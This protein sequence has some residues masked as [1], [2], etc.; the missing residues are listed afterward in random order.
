M[1]CI[2]YVFALRFREVLTLCQ[3]DVFFSNTFMGQSYNPSAMLGC[4][5]TV[6][7][8]QHIW[9]NRLQQS[10]MVLAST[11]QLPQYKTLKQN[12]FSAAAADIV[13]RQLINMIADAK[14]FADPPYEVFNAAN[15]G[16]EP[17]MRVGYKR[18]DGMTTQIH[19]GRVDYFML[20]SFCCITIYR[21]SQATKLL[22]PGC[23][24]LRRKL[25]PVRLLRSNSNFK[26]RAVSFHTQAFRKIILT[27]S[28]VSLALCHASL[29][30]SA[31]SF[32]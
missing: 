11:K 20:K 9:N 23:A 30:T 3:V 4:E 1:R 2:V 8:M 10:H 27:A 25:C 21:S 24:K 16:A 13:D 15:K 26:F 28:W 22:S 31:N 18:L 17:Q 29:Q 7:L 12:T 19:Y 14:N 32:S 5:N 6:T